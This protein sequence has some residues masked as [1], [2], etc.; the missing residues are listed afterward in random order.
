MSGAPSQP[1]NVAC[2]A[3][4]YP[5][6]VHKKQNEIDELGEK[7]DRFDAKIESLVDKHINERRVQSQESNQVSNFSCFVCGN[8]TILHSIGLIII[9]EI[10]F[11]RTTGEI[12]VGEVEAIK[13]HKEAVT[14]GVEE[15]VLEKGMA[16]KKKCP[17]D[18][19]ASK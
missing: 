14:T 19:A 16:I 4:Y 17:A 5:S 1:L 8:P 7:L 6:H 10:S 9:P 2:P 11:G 3:T 15:V 18:R 12:M 13:T